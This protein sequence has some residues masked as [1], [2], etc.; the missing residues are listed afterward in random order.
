MTHDGVTYPGGGSRKNASAQTTGAVRT[1]NCAGFF[2]G[3]IR[4]PECRKQ[5][6]KRICLHLRL[7]YGV[8]KT[9]VKYYCVSSQTK[10]KQIK[11]LPVIALHEYGLR[12][13]VRNITLECPEG[14]QMI[15]NTETPNPPYGFS[16]EDHPEHKPRLSIGYASTIGRK[17]PV[18]CINRVVC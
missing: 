1:E 15:L 8:G 14:G 16:G 6:L 17:H 12:K 10:G 3:R 5:H 18:I 11:A 2:W 7:V 4:N 13:G 9:R